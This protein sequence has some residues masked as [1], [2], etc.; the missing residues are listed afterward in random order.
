M[1]SLSQSLGPK[2]WKSL[3]SPYVQSDLMIG[4]I[5]IEITHYA[6]IAIYSVYRIQHP[7]HSGIIHMC[8]MWIVNVYAIYAIL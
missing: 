8:D 5:D 6:V 3:T 4:F 2:Q 1:L 7:Y